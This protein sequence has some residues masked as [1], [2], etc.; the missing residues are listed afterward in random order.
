MLSNDREFFDDPRRA[1]ITLPCMLKLVISMSKDNSAC[2][3]K[4]VES[5][6]YKEKKNFITA[7][8]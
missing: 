4:D 6:S 1:C 8:L 5:K 7:L 2:D 3:V